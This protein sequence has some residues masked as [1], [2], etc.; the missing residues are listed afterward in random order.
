MLLLDVT[1]HALT[2]SLLLVIYSILCLNA[3]LL[4]V[5]VIAVLVFFRHL[6]P[7]HLIPKDFLLSEVI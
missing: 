5:Y 6:P 2:S 7:N 4:G 1:R 3:F